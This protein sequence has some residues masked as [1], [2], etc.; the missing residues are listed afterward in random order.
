MIV[1]LDANSY[2]VIEDSGVGAQEQ[3][4]A[5]CVE[6]LNDNIVISVD[7]LLTIIPGT[8]IRKLHQ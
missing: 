1:T 2:D 6:A 3:N 4:V 5:I 8:A 7:I